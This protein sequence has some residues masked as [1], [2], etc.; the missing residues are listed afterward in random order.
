VVHFAFNPTAKRL[1]WKLDSGQWTGVVLKTDD[2]QTMQ[3]FLQSQ[4]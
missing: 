3:K 4:K 1:T 2:V